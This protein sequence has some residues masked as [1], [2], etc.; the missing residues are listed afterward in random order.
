LQNLSGGTH[1]KKRSPERLRKIHQRRRVEE[2]K[3]WSFMGSPNPLATVE[4]M[5]A[6]FVQCKKNVVQCGIEIFM[7]ASISQMQD[8][9]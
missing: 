3:P 6:S 7:W 1:K 2:T 5:A 8:R 9:G 4:I